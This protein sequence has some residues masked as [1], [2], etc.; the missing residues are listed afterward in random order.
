METHTIS[1]YARPGRFGRFQAECGQMVAGAQHAAQPTCPRC[2]ELQAE[3]DAAI[4]ALRQMP[5]A[6]VG[7]K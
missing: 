2:R 1:G 7:V 4:S 3:D 6:R 5:S